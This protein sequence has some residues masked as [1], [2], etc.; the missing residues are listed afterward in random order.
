MDNDQIRKRLSINDLSLVI[1]DGMR[2]EDII[3]QIQPGVTTGLLSIRDGEFLQIHTDRSRFPFYMELESKVGEVYYFR[4]KLK[5]TLYAVFGDEAATIFCP[6]LNRGDNM[7]KVAS[8]SQ[9]GLTTISV[10]DKIEPVELTE[11][12][13]DD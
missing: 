13:L 1:E 3:S 9:D 10:T 7:R 12:L 6:S 5:N 8:I 11:R 2:F 4:D